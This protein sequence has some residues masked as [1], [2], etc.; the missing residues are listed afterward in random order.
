M[1]TPTLETGRL[2]L[3]KFT[4]YDLEALFLILKDEEV[5]RFLPWYPIKD[6]EETKK[7]YEERYAS[8]YA[9]P[10]AYAYAICLKED[11][12][13]IGYIKVDMEE[14]HD[15]GYGLRKEFW[16]KGIVSEAGKAV[17]EQVKNDGLPYI[18]AT[19]DR[20]NPRSGNVMRAC[21][22][23]YCYTY[24]ELWQ[25]KNFLVEFRLYQ[26]NFTKEDNWMYK[27]YWDKYPIHFIEKL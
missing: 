8:K 3:R 7:F 25:P 24:Q 12:Y 13:P 2:I 23:K 15:F 10:Q 26:L 16:H 21:G 17:V 5:N 20:N 11:N 22:M 27:E 1:N 14:H 6:L 9:Q 19:H 4:E 18:T